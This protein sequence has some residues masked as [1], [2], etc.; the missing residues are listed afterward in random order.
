MTGDGVNDAPALKAANIGIA[1][2]GRGADVA[3]EAAALVLLDDAFESIVAAI[4]MGRR[5]FDNLRKALSYI[6]AVHVPIAGLALLPLLFGWPIVF[7][8]VHVVFLE[9]IIDPA[10]SIAFE[11]EPEE[12]DTMS[13][14]PRKASA[15]LFDSRDI[16]IGI[17][18]GAIGL[19]GLLAM[20]A[21]VLARGVGEEEAR[22]MA[23][24][25]IVIVNIALILANRSRWQSVFSSLTRPNSF[26]WWIV[27]A[28]IGVLLLA[29]YVQPVADLF[30]F[31]PLSMGQLLFTVAP[32]A[33]MLA[34]TELLKTLRRRAYR[35]RALEEGSS[36]P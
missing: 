14:G 24:A 35:V 30:R 27:G 8:P 29:I 2:G 6:L 33:L 10:C 32:A 3:R 31:A 12:P 16:I 36:H 23:F 4:R 13:R 22:A 18:Q 25:G 26:L 11:A 20:Y 34:A 5:I 21:L 17:S 7:F 1:M 28:A 15:A 19:V 9:L